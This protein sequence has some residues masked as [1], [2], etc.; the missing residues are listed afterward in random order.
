ELGETNTENLKNEDYTK[1]MN[2][3]FDKVYNEYVKK[4]NKIITNLLDPSNYS[5]ELPK[6]VVVKPDMSSGFGNRMPGIICGFLY[7]LI[8]DRLFFM[9]G[10]QNFDNYFEK[11]F[12]HN[13]DTVSYLYSGSTAKD[14]HFM[15][16]INNFT[17]LTRGNFSSEEINSYD[18]LRVYT[19]DYICAPLSSNP[20]YK[21]WFNKII[22]DYRIF[23]TI[24]LRLL[25]LHPDLKSQVEDYSNNNFND[26][27]IGIHLRENK[28]KTPWMIPIEHYYEAARML[29]LEVKN[30]NISIFV[31]ADTNDGHNMDLHNSIMWEN[32]GTE[33]GAIIDLKLL[34]LCDDLVIT[35]AS[36]FGLLAAGWTHKASR[37]RGLFV[38]N[39]IKKNLIENLQVVDKVWMW[40]AISSEPC[41]YMSKFLFEH[42]D[43][44]NVRIFKSNPLWIHYS[45]CS[46]AIS[47]PHV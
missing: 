19:L 45:Q 15:E 29:M 3:E 7:S 40:G 43:E 2:P 44:E 8:S 37:Q 10:Y 26:Y 35:Y 9:D 14:L 34:G 12:D 24:S 20:Y 5:S 13:W 22:P 27:N 46:F 21:E 42:E 32:S 6:V 30:K 28:F 41:M 47:K 39:P 38:I 16:K 1:Y 18:I 33:A 31:A 23:T 11:D 17:L 36:S 4:H 25:R